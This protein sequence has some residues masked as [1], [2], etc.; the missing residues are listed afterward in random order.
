VAVLACLLNVLGIL[1]TVAAAYLAW[2]AIDNGNKQA[3]RSMDALQRERRID[4]E[5][6]HL[7]HLLS[8][9]VSGQPSHRLF[10]SL[11][12]LPADDPH[13]LRARAWFLSEQNARWGEVSRIRETAAGQGVTWSLLTDA[14]VNGGTPYSDTL[15]TDIQDAIQ[16]R[17]DARDLS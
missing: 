1:A 10:M 15:T 12:L 9:V 3:K 2:K 5:L 13:L 11:R 7:E 6:D 17:L 16:A 14:N 8:E 4:F